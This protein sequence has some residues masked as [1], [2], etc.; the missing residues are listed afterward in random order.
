MGDTMSSW[1]NSS[2]DTSTTG[3]ESLGNS[4]FSTNPDNYVSTSSANTQSNIDAGKTGMDNYVQ[5]DNGSTVGTNSSIPNGNISNA[6]DSIVGSKSDQAKGAKQEEGSQLLNDALNTVTKTAAQNPTPGGIISGV[7]KAAIGAAKTGETM[8][9]SNLNPVSSI[10]A[11]VGTFGA[12]TSAS[13]PM[14]AGK[15]AESGFSI[16]PTT[17]APTLQNSLNNSPAQS[18]GFSLD[19]ANGGTVNDKTFFDTVRDKV[20]KAQPYINT[21]KTLTSLNPGIPSTPA[22]NTTI[23]SSSTYKQ[24]YSSKKQVRRYA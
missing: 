7:A 2:G 3:A 17:E 21:Y 1:L 15:S 10:P 23:N 4:Q 22:Q 16:S 24:P 13:N 11:S 14:A 20:E 6:L 5:T 19:T 8:G 12:D 9:Q 18:S